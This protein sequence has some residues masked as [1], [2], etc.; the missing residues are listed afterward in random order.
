[1]DFILFDFNRS[2]LLPFTYTRAVATIRTGI[3]TMQERW[4]KAL[5]APT[6]ILT[7]TYLQP[8][9]TLQPSAEAIYI[10]A[11][12]VADE[13]LLIAILSLTSGDKLMKGNELLAMRPSDNW[14]TLAEL[15]AG[16]SYMQTIH[17]EHPLL[18]LKHVWDLFAHND[19]IIKRDF[20]TIT[21]GRQSAALPKDIWVKG[22]ENIFVEEGA[23]IGA[24]TIINATTGPVYI[25][26]EAEIMEGCTIRGPLALCTH[27]VL[28][29]GA[30][31]YGGCTIG[32]GCKV[33]GEVSNVVFFANSNKGHDGFLGNSVVGEWCNL[34]A[35]TNSSNL[36]NNY[37]EVKIWDINSNQLIKTGLT[38]CG[39][40]MG[41]HSKCGINTMFNTGTVVGVSCNIFGGNFPEKYLPSF[42]W[43]GSDG[44]ETYTFGKAM[45]TANRMMAR[46]GKQL[47]EAEMA[48]YQHLFDTR[49][50]LI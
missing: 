47:S 9:Y 29:M 23:I 6:Q 16:V 15:E 14:L 19:A 48:M 27:A 25:G 10:N 39:L 22:A 37:D 18:Q 3:Y 45:E 50:E 17:Y 34:G 20:A 35:D 4:E 13:Q 21:A 12:L 24:G 33:G 41:D 2:S 7:D 46:R 8:L 49:K 38:F 11:G 43:G 36:K 42:A 26:A 44:I 32:E 5:N 28:K 1:M 31:V 40:L 30:K